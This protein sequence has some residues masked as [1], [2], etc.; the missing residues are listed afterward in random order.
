[1]LCDGDRLVQVLVHLIMEA[2]RRSPPGARLSIQAGETEANMVEVKI[3]ALGPITTGQAQA[4][5]SSLLAGSGANLKDS[6]LA[7][8]ICTGILAAHKGT[9]GINLEGVEGP[10][11]WFKIPLPEDE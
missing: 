8:A 7:L 2:I 10:Q 11:S 9:L 5:A 3:S 1:L 4:R 6:G